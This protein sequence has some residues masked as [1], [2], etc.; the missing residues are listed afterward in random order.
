MQRSPNLDFQHS[1]LAGVSAGDMKYAESEC[2]N[3]NLQ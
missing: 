3:T 2:Y 1:V